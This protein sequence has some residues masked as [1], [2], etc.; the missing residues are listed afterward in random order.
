MLSAFLEW[1]LEVVLELLF[2]RR[3]WWITLMVLLG[4]GLIIA[5]S[6]SRS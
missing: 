5:C 4:L 3:Y 2:S 6:C 1:V